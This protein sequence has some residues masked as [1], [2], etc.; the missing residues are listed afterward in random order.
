MLCTKTRYN[1]KIFINFINFSY[2]FFWGQIFQYPQI[3]YYYRYC[4]LSICTTW[5]FSKIECMLYCF[6]SFGWLS[7]GTY[8]LKLLFLVEKRRRV[9]EELWN[10]LI[11]TTFEDLLKWELSSTGMTNLHWEHIKFW[12]LHSWHR[13]SSFRGW[14]NEYKKLLE[15]SRSKV[16]NL[17]VVELQPWGS[18]ILYK[19]GP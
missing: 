13:A 17:L 12:W 4:F 16:N 9:R 10:F 18:W 15:T 19:K 5:G 7:I 6:Q 8:F 14:P 11:Q 3:I 2:M 1:S